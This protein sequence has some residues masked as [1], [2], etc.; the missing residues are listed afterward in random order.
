MRRY[1]LYIS[2]NFWTLVTTS[3]PPVPQFWIYS[4]SIS[5]S[6]SAAIS[7]DDN[8]S[9]LLALMK[10]LNVVTKKLFLMLKNWENT[11][12][13]KVWYLRVWRRKEENIP[14][15]GRWRCRERGMRYFAF[16]VFADDGDTRKILKNL[17][18]LLIRKSQEKL[19][20]ELILMPGIFDK[21]EY[22][23]SAINCSHFVDM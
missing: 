23:N 16:P 9:K 6:N 14:G 21:L 17:C 20:T 11:I 10:F 22:K 1:L 13:F 12:I 15:V 2:W 19:Q 3:V 5:K 4:K 8:T 7:P 18:L